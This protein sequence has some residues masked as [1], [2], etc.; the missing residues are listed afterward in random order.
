MRHRHLDDYIK[1]LKVC[2]YFTYEGIKNLVSRYPNVD[3]IKIA[4]AIK[5][6]NEAKVSK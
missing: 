1:A 6:K 4:L 2:K 3:H 5:A